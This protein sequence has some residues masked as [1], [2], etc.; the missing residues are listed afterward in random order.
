M[1]MSKKEITDELLKQKELLGIKNEKQAETIVSAFFNILKEK[2]EHLDYDK[3]F[4]LHTIGSFYAV[5]LEERKY[6][7]AHS[8]KIA[9]LPSHRRIRFRGYRPFQSSSCPK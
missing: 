4:R 1:N 3:S 8:G 5:K 9:I 7:N 6:R 2:L